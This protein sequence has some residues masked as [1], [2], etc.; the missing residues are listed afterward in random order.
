[1]KGYRTLALAAAC[2]LSPA[3]GPC[4]THYVSPEGSDEAPYLT[5]ETAATTIQA[6]VDAATAGDT[7]SVA[8]GDYEEHVVMSDGLALLGSGPDKSRIWGSIGAGVDA[9]IRRLAIRQE[10]PENDARFARVA[11][12]GPRTGGLMVIDCFISGTFWAGIECRM[13]G[14]VVLIQRCE[15]RGIR[16]GEAGA[17]I[18]LDG[19]GPALAVVHQCAIADNLRGVST[20]SRVDLWVSRTSVTRS[21][22]CG[23]ELFGPAVVTACSIDRND[24]AVRVSAYPGSVSIQSST[25]CQNAEYGVVC[26]DLALVQLTCCT[27]AHNGRAGVVAGHSADLVAQRSIIWGNGLEDVSLPGLGATFTASDSCV[28]GYCEDSYCGPGNIDADPLFVDPDRGNYRLRAASP[29]IDRWR[30]GASDPRYAFDK[31]GKRRLAYG[32]GDGSAA[33]DMGAYEYYIN[34]LT[35]G[36][37]PDEATLTWSSLAD[38]TYSVFYTDDLLTWHLGVQNFPSA[39][40]KTTSWVDDG[41]K[42]GIAP[43]LAPKRF[44]RMLENP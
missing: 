8:P 31:D 12:L 28:G 38:K 11:L 21:A 43:L 32:G 37:G 41:S 34:E 5:P 30:M 14:G 20:T 15:L 3:G 35:A 4:D 1:M 13:Q 10:C 22:C 17:A 26:A 16:A 23:L 6:A 25:L 18:D 19:F 24:E 9:E 33:V 39:G 27:I 36:P 7:V 2:L 42:T 44:Y 40:Y 29:C